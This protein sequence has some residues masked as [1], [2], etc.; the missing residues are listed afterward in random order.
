MNFYVLFTIYVGFYSFIY[1]AEEKEHLKA[2]STS[3]AVPLPQKLMGIEIETST[4]KLASPTTSKIGFYFRIPSDGRCIWILEED[5]LDPTFSESA[6]LAEFDQNVE[7]KTHGGFTFEAINEVAADLEMMIALLYERA[8]PAPF[9]ANPQLLEEMQNHKYTVTPK[10]HPQTP[11]LIKSK[12]ILLADQRAIKPQITYQLPLQEIPRIFERLRGFEHQGITYLM[13]DL[14]DAPFTIT[15]SQIIAEKLKGTH[16]QRITAKLL[17]N[18]DA[19]EP[20]R[21]YFHD[22]IAPQFAVMPEGRVKGFTLLFLHYWY[23][24]FNNKKTIGSEPGLKQYLGIMSRIPLS[25]LYDSLDEQEKIAFQEFMEPH[26]N[27]GHQCTLRAYLD[28]DEEA[29]KIPFILT[30]WFSSI[31]DN[32]YRQNI[33]SRNVDLLSPPPSLPGHSMGILDINSHAN[34]V[35]LLE[36]RGYGELRYGGMNLTIYRIRELVDGESKWFFEVL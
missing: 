12:E 33:N 11:F 4:L 15:N 1:P 29:V 2:A 21:R 22:V 6:D 31:I 34:T 8:L 9:E 25:Q 35:A 26:V 13:R 28:E 36:V 30:H 7:I 24:L 32:Q 5:T 3:I 17:Q 27:F 19:G 14:S 20:V 23:E 16:L 18:K 10:Q